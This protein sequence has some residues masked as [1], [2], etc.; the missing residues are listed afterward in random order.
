[1][2]LIKPDFDKKDDCVKICKKYH[3]PL[4]HMFILIYIK[5]FKNKFKEYKS[6]M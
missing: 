4:I 5:I 3:V 1:M 6:R 2:P